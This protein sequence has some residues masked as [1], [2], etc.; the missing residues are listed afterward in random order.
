M[1]IPGG[2]GLGGLTIVGPAFC[3]GLVAG[4]AALAG[5][6]AFGPIDTT[7]PRAS[8]ALTP[9]LILCLS[10]IAV[11]LTLWRYWPAPQARLF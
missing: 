5:H 7:M 11:G 2:L 4:L 8:G 1:R 6:A 3:A 9:W 10:T